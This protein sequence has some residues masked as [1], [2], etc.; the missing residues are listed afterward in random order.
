MMS[1]N[2]L[3]STIIIF[4]NTEKFIAEAIES[5]FAQTYQNWELLVVD[6]GSTDGSTAIAKHY[7]EAY[8]EKVRY[9][10][11]SHHQNRGMSASRNLGINQA[12]G[13]YV[14][15]LDADDVWLP[16]KVEQQVAILNSEPE[17]AMVY[18]RTQIWYSW[19][20]RPEDSERDHFYEL[21]VEPNTL[22]KPPNLFFL[23]LQN[24]TQTPTTCNVMIRREVFSTIGNFEEHFRG[25]YE[26]QAFFAKIQLKTSVYVAN[27]V[28]AKYRQHPYSCS[29]KAETQQYY[30]ARLPFLQ[31][32]RIYLEEQNVQ[33]PE[34]WKVLRRE[35][36]QCHHPILFSLIKQIQYRLGQAKEIFPV[37]L[38]VR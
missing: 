23:L 7:A 6:D 3:V 38:A 9:L 2:P 36:W 5:V 33:E 24:K 15:F 19:T 28:W 16:S 4:L 13:E 8:P 18:G 25:M 34:V 29:S 22:I 30:V 20:G 12:Q 21:G 14:A 11:H 35:L 26:D 32:L 17:A 37:K 31:W 1:R 10:E 27:E